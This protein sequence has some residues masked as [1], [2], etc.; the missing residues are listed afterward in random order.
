MQIQYYKMLLTMLRKLKENS[1]LFRDY[2]KQHLTQ[3]CQLMQM[4]VMILC[5]NTELQTLHVTNAHGMVII[6]RTTPSMLALV[7]G[8]IKTGKCDITGL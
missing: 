8:Q 1:P 7:Q 2:S 5:D 6:E 4:P 3:S